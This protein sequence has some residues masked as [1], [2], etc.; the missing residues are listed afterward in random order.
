[1]QAVNLSNRKTLQEK[2]LYKNIIIGKVTQ[3]TF[4]VQK[5]VPNPAVE[6]I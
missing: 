4:A 2:Q 5:C 3:S 6:M 1:M